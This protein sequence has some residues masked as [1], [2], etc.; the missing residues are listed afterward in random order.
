MTARPLD[1]LAGLGQAPWLDSLSRDWLRSGEL[2]RLRDRYA[3]LGVTSNPSIFRESLRSQVYDDDIRRLS[4]AG[5]ADEHLFEALAVADIRDAC[6]IFSDVHRTT[7]DGHVSLELDPGHADDEAASVIQARSLWHTVDRPNLM[8]KVPGTVAGVAVAERLIGEGINVN[9]TLLFGVDV[10]RQVME[11]HMRGLERLVDG[12]GDPASVQSV[13]SFFVSRVDTKVD[14]L[15]QSAAPD[16]GLDGRIAIA[17]AT[18]AWSGH[19]QVLETA[20]WQRLADHGARP[21]RPLWASTGTKNAAY[22][23]VRYVEGLVAHGTVNTMPLATI[24]AFDDHGTARVALDDAAV[25]RARGRIA[26]LAE[27]GISLDAVTAELRAEGIAAF[28]EAH[29]D[30]V[31]D[32]A[33]RRR[34]LST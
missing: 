32:L 23:D 3:L 15:L 26:E 18:L 33:R 4:A 27:C 12:G 20:R 2:E 11:A 5:I 30:L 29:D 34:Q 7:G 31:A 17:N 6:D 16:S 8:V 9:V 14:L 1:Q 19:R 28:A 22:E 10:Y 13:A 21:Q 25:D 24:Q